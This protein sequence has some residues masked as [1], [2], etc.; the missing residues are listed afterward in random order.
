MGD[1]Y[2][3]R[4]NEWMANPRQGDSWFEIF[5]PDSLPVDLA[6]LWLTDDPSFA[7]LTNRPSLPPLSFIGAES[8]LPFIADGDPLQPLTRLRHLMIAGRP[9]ALRSHHTQL[10]EQWR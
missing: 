5:N 3:L 10:Y 1:R 9:I 8:W 2:R 4:I 6:G 7:G